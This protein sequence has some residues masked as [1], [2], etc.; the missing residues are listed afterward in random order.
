MLS[1]YLPASL[2]MYFI[3][4]LYGISYHY[5]GELTNSLSHVATANT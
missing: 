4:I 1:H 5:V 3:P 2:S